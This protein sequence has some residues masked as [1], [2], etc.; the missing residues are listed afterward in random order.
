MSC[1]LNDIM[2]DTGCVHFDIRITQLSFCQV[3]RASGIKCDVSLSYLTV[4]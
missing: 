4:G 2:E 1:H 3:C